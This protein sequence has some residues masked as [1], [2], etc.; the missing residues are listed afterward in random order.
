MRAHRNFLRHSPSQVRIRGPWCIPADKD[1]C[2]NKSRYIVQV[3]RVRGWHNSQVSLSETSNEKMSTVRSIGSKRSNSLTHVSSVVAFARAT[4][5]G[6]P[7]ARSPAQTSCP[8]FP[9]ASLLSVMSV[10]VIGKRSVHV[11]EIE[12]EELSIPVESIDLP[13]S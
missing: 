12:L 11:V 5:R 8:C 1:S 2:E 3:A 9:Y 7:G 4:S 6:A 10:V 13:P